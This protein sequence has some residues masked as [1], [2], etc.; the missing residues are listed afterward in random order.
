MDATDLQLS[1]GEGSPGL[2]P[3]GTDDAWRELGTRLRSLR[4][5]RILRGLSQ[6][7]LRDLADAMRPLDLPAD[8]T[9]CRAGDPVRH[10]FILV[11][12]RWDVP[13]NVIG[14]AAPRRDDAAT[15]E[16][17]N[18][19]P[20]EPRRHGCTACTLTAA[21][22][23]TVPL[24]TLDQVTAASVTSGVRRPGLSVD[25]AGVGQRLGRRPGRQ[26]LRDVTFRVA[27][28]ELVA[29]VGSSG[30]GKTMLLETM[31]GLR[32]PVEGVVRYD[33]V[34]RHTNPAL[35]R[36]S[37]GYVPQ[38]D[39]IHRT[40]S[41][42]RTLWHAAR[43]RLPADSSPRHLTDAVRHVLGELGLAHLASA[44]VRSLSGGERK[45]ACVA[46]EL[47]TRPRVFFLDEPTS[48]LDPATAAD[49]MRLLRRLA[50]GGTTVV[51]ATHNVSDLRVCDSVV[52]MAQDGN[53]AFAGPVDRA[54]HYFGTA[55]IEEV[56]GRL[57]YEDTPQTWGR[58]F[59]RDQEHVPSSPT[60]QSFSAGGTDKPSSG[61][62]GQ[63]PGAVR[64]WH[65][66][67]RRNVEILA[68]D[69]LTLAILLG[70]PVMILLMFVVL[71]RPHAFTA[72]NP[73][74]GATMMTAFWVTFG[75]FFFGVTY[76]LPQICGELAILRRERLVGVRLGPYVLSKLAVLLPLLVA[77]DTITIG[78]LRA[79][80]RLPALGVAQA[81]TLLV[82]LLLAST[83]ALCLGLLT[84]AAVFNP[85]QATVA[86]PMLCF[87][88]VLF[89]GAI[90]PIPA[91]APAGKAI[92]YAMSNRW[93]FEGFGHSVG[94]ERLWAHGGSPLGPPLLASY[95]TTF[96]HAA[97]LDWAILS[98]FTTM[99]LAATYL[100]LNARFSVRPVRSA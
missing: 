60:P 73:D 29:I 91:M 38:D 36:S 59:A 96:T 61:S 25:V 93:A 35:F 92:S 42:E 95:G 1:T 63:P 87:P 50:D 3:D 45:R 13:G 80:D 76:G 54:C 97:W 18:A 32:A 22:V 70:S 19:T 55:T 77:V 4:E 98:G 81:A 43:L 47:L 28:G 84:S 58:R 74:P 41:L 34:D 99:L 8:A 26:T 39:I 100:V 21:R 11:S 6:A 12:G 68:R 53:L 49:L 31:A 78:L 64:Q 94:L 72:G 82:T 40:L 23:W 14:L 62:A 17:G 86:L 51:L 15:G 9:V 52:F 30:A 65:L 20:D 57:A 88:Q 16:P 37:L 27:P 56:Y 48:G 10:L 83:A 71:F 7:A 89:S 67:T 66:L 44:E 69:R 90:L 2:P 24:T 46:V 79:L 33:G 5:V 85:A 75:G